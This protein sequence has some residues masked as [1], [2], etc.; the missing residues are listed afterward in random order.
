MV[1][2][3]EQ[4]VG[5]GVAL[6]LRDRPVRRAWGV[7]AVA[8]AVWLSLCERRRDRRLHRG[9]FFGESSLLIFYVLKKTRRGRDWFAASLW[10]FTFAARPPGRGVCGPVGRQPCPLSSTP[11]AKRSRLSL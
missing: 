4:V 5:S 2:S 8:L 1:H 3:D 11:R 9:E 6:L 7:W 10:S